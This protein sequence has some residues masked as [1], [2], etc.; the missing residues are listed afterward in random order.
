MKATF[1][2][3]LFI[4]I[5]FYVG[6]AFPT[7]PKIMVIPMDSWCQENGFWTMYENQGQI[8][9]SPNYEQAFQ[10]SRDLM[11][12]V[13]KINT[14]MADRGF[15]LADMSQSIKNNARRTARNS[16]TVSKTTGSQLLTSSLDELN[17]Q[18]KAD[19]YIEVDFSINNVGPKKSLT[20]NIR[21]L[22]SYTGKQVAGAGGTGIPT[23][24]SEVPVLLEEAVIG[25]MDNFIA[26]L[27]SYFDD[28]RTYG[29][30]ITLELGVFD[31]NAG[32]DLES[33]FDGIELSEIIEK[34]IA[35]NTINSQYLTSESTESILLFENVRIPLL[36]EN[37]NPQDA[38][39]F[40]N[41]LRKFLGKNYGLKT[42]NNSP[43]LGY[44]QIIIGDK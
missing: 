30:E 2:G 29:R 26:R 12:V 25:H 28:C 6:H 4:L 43:S 44:A 9:G 27:Q 18:A 35:D 36:K 42:K 24:T 15:P 34:W 33:E 5:T 1:I 39:G 7:N 16:L 22:D 40:A 8:I 41:E 13:S 14:L 21:A 11:Q 31:S 19:I 20:Y 10:E 3:F 38:G 37:G 23:F 17:R 32:I